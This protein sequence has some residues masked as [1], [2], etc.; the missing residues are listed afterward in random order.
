MLDERE[1]E[2]W[3]MLYDAGIRQL[4]HQPCATLRLGRRR[5]RLESMLWSLSTSDHGEAFFEHDSSAS[6]TEDTHYQEQ[7]RDPTNHGGR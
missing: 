3:R 2:Q 7:I 5:G 1:R 6:A 4:D